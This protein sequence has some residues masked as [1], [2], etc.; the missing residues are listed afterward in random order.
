MKKMMMDNYTLCL[1]GWYFGIWPGEVAGHGWTPADVQAAQR[2]C[3]EHH[4]DPEL[5]WSHEAELS[6]NYSEK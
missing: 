2:M 5:Y 3:E 1:M 4:I 6:F